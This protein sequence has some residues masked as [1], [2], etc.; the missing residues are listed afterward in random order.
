[1]VSKFSEALKV[2]FAEEHAEL[3]RQ[4]GE[5]DMETD[6]NGQSGSGGGGNKGGKQKGKNNKKKA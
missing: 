6:E 5:D 2:V 3:W 1:M 4:G